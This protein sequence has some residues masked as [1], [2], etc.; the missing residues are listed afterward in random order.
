MNRLFGY[1]EPA[2]PSEN[3]TLPNLPSSWYRSEA[4]YNLERRAIYSKKWVLVSHEV[5]FPEPGNYLQLQEAGFAFFLIRDR[6]GK[7]NS[8]HNVCRHCAYPVV[9]EQ[10]GKVNILS[11][12]YHGWSYGLNG[13]LAKAPRYQE[14]DGF[15]KEENGLF[16]IHVHID[17]LGFI[18]INLDAS[19]T[20]AVAWEDDFAG[21]DEQPRLKPFDFSQYR[22]DHMWDMVGDYNWK[23]L[24]DNY[25]EVRSSTSYRFQ[26]AAADHVLL[27]CYHCPTGHPGLTQYTDMGK[28]WV[29]TKASHIQHFNTDRPDQEGM[30]IISTFYFPNASMTVSKDFFYIMRC[31]PISPS[32]THMEYEIYRHGDATDE[33]FNK[34]DQIF[35]QVLKEDKDLCNAAQKNLN[36]GVYVHGN[37]HP[38][39]EKGPLFFQKTVK[40]LVMSHHES[41]EKQGREIW[42]ATP[43]PV[44]TNE[45]SEEMDF[46]RK[47]DCLAKNEN[48]GLFSW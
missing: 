34:I 3:A 11:C 36:A 38:Q 29:E 46:C 4:M 12:R 15:D 1:R 7:I 35:K 2:K 19:E 8:F 44:M 20:P 32:Q 42:A 45:L 30:G 31:V 9:Q 28:Y 10:A 17:K 40:D 16:P 27:K 24:A 43:V 13:K 47:I 5:R 41:E 22:F 25:N 39:H 14:L 33:D 18:W 21:V 26:R 48:N 6:Q 37:L 23:T